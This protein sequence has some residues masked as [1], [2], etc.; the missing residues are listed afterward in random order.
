MSS[1][2]PRDVEL[3]PV[4]KH[5]NSSTEI[6]LG[7]SSYSL[8]GQANV[9]QGILLPSTKTTEG[10]PRYERNIKAGSLHSLTGAPALSGM[11]S[12]S[13][14]KN[15]SP[16]N[17]GRAAN[18]SKSLSN[19]SADSSLI[20]STP[21]AQKKGNV[22]LST[23]AH[24]LSG[25]ALMGPGLFLPRDTLQV[26]QPAATNQRN[27]AAPMATTEELSPSP[28][29]YKPPPAAS[30]R[31]LASDQKYPPKQSLLSDMQIHKNPRAVASDVK[32]RG[33]GMMQ[34]EQSPRHVG[35]KTA[36]LEAAPQ[37]PD[38]DAKRQ[39]HRREAGNDGRSRPAA[40]RPDVN[41]NKDRGRRC[42]TDRS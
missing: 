12:T 11:N 23:S 38:S 1:L 7:A 34:Y 40:N 33:V 19:L 17:Q 4:N 18:S 21:T 32:G 6:L 41:R 13:F 9:S 20:H 22:T 3:M 37:F 35:Y 36:A 5:L 39:R 16:L 25:G 29:S 15:I 42:R 30:T 10:A 14:Q 28:M 26:R 2:S 31:P 8:S 24:S 27:R